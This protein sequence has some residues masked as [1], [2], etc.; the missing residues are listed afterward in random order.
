MQSMF[1]FP[2]LNETMPMTGMPT[3]HVPA[4]SPFPLDSLVDAN[5]NTSRKS[6]CPW[7]L[8]EKELQVKIFLCPRVVSVRLSG[9]IQRKE[10]RR[11]NQ[12]KTWRTI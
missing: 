6:C 5:K 2:V 12:E 1:V 8:T 11:A 4:K 9:K 3:N 10:S 7:I